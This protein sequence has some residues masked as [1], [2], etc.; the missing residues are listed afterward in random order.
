MATAASLKVVHLS[1]AHYAGDT[2]ILHKECRSLANAGH[3]VTLVARHERDTIVG[4]VKIKAL[5]NPKSRWDRWTSALWRVYRQVAGLHADLY[6]FH[7]PELIPVGMWLSLQGKRVIYDAHEDL[8]NTFAYK[9]YIPAFA[10]KTLAWLAGRIENLAVRRFAAVVAATPTIAQRFSEYNTNTVVVRNFPSLAEL[11]LAPKLPWNDR[12]PLVVYVGSMAPERGFREAV[13]AISLLPEELNARLAFGGPVT[14]E[15]REEIGRL[16]GSD[17]TDLLGV[18]GRVE[19]A[20]LLGRARYFKIREWPL[21]GRTISL[22]DLEHEKIQPLS[23]PRI[24]FAIV[25]ASRSCPPLR[26]EAYAAA[27]LDAQL[28]EQARSFIN[29]PAR[30]RFDKATR[31]AHLSEIFDWYD[32]DFRAATGSTQRFIARYVADADVARDLAADRYKLEWIPYDWRLN[33]IPL[34][35]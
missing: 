30:N 22:Y 26:S 29:D 34:R 27:R 33:G 6:H 23:E 13:T 19:V 7:D 11:M 18:L 9:Y 31:T 21:N 35:Q 15:L 12:P 20:S 1:S 24:H 16:R 3:D 4:G 2:R 8:P 5:C 14:P 32:M 28:D 17:R 10:R 25:C